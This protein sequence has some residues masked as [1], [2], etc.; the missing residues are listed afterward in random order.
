MPDADRERQSVVELLTELLGQNEVR[1]H[2]APHLIVW[3]R[4]HVG[5][6]H[7]GDTKVSQP[8]KVSLAKGVDVPAGDGEGGKGG[9]GSTGEQTGDLGSELAHDASPAFVGVKATRR[10]D[11]YRVTIV[12][13]S[14]HSLEVL[15]VGVRLIR[16]HLR[17]RE[18]IRP[19][20][21]LTGCL[22]RQAV[23]C[24]ANDT[25]HSSLIP[26]ATVESQN[27]AP[28]RRIVRWEPQTMELTGA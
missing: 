19:K 20:H 13:P 11:A 18:E 22:R 16:P 10:H 15:S 25:G 8:L 6:K 2:V 26:S 24:L 17:E 27:T 12:N 4:P 21:P 7:L 23:G 28:V 3:R 5:Q 1:R 9:F 14:G